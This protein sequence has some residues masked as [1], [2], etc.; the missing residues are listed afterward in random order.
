MICNSFG[1]KVIE[2]TQKRLELEGAYD[3]AKVFTY[4]KSCGYRNLIGL[5]N[6]CAYETSKHHD[7]KEVIQ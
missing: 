5:A 1:K 2:N 4:I 6:F 3:Y 7:F